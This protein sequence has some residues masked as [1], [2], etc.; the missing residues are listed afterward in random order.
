MNSSNNLVGKI[1]FIYL[2]VFSMLQTSCSDNSKTTKNI[3]QKIVKKMID[4]AVG[5]PEAFSFSEIKGV[6]YST[7]FMSEG[8]N[9]IKMTGI[10]DGQTFTGD[11]KTITP[12]YPNE[13]VKNQPFGYWL[14][15]GNESVQINIIT[16]KNRQSFAIITE[17]NEFYTK[18]IEEFDKDKVAIEI[19]QHMS[20]EQSN[21]MKKEYHFQIFSPFSPRLFFGSTGFVD[22]GYGALSGWILDKMYDDDNGTS[23]LAVRYSLKEGFQKEIGQ[24]FLYGFIAIKY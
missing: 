13:R 19:L 21:I 1:L 5:L 4:N 18:Q 16:R 6:L 8:V 20:T 9:L 17:S 14:A 2:V 12:N 7:N 23:I 24:E 3:Q 15:D 10:E 11:T 22:Q